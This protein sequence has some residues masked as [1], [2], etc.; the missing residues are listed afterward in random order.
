MRSREAFAFTP[1]LPDRRVDYLEALDEEVYHGDIAASEEAAAS[2]ASA[3]EA[4]ASETAEASEAASSAA[5]LK[6]LGA[7]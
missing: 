5:D 7:L 1:L 4:E 6:S 3:R 2:S